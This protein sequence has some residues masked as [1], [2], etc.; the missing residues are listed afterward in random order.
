MI[1]GVGMDLCQIERI[2][3]A[4]AKPRFMERVFTPAERARIEAAGGVRHGEIAAGT[5]A[6]K[7][8]VAKALGTGFAGL[9]P[10]DIEIVPD[11]LG[12]PRCTLSGGALARAEALCGKG[13]RVWLSITHENGMAAAMAILESG[14]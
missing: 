5:F 11:D 9:G 12:R 2:E 14:A 3:K 13:P 10:W 6:A 1:L 8:A 7:E 4:I